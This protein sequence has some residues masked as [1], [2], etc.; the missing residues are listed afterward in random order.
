MLTG[1]SAVIAVRLRRVFDILFNGV[2]WDNEALSLMTKKCAPNR[3]PFQIVLLRLSTLSQ[4]QPYVITKRAVWA[5]R[6]T[7]LRESLET[8]YLRPSLSLP[9]GFEYWHHRHFSFNQSRKNDQS[10]EIK[11]KQKK[12]FP[13]FNFFSPSEE[14]LRGRR[15]RISNVC[16]RL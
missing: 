6:V 16:Y 10:K 14:L 8:E 15:E 1:V 2:K 7:L 11:R 4:K 3:H 12:N 9:A 5:Y 13:F